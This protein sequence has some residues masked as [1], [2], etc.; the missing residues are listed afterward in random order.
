MPLCT[1]CYNFDLNQLRNAPSGN[2]SNTLS[3]I[4]KSALGGCDLCS[5]VVGVAV[6]H[7]AKVSKHPEAR[8][9]DHIWIQ[10]WLSGNSTSS[11][12]PPRYNKLLVSINTLGRFLPTASEIGGLYTTSP[13]QFEHEICIAASPGSPAYQSGV[14]GGRYLGL[15]KTSAEYIA[16]IGEWMQACISSH[17]E[18]CR[19]ISDGAV[20]D[21]HSVQ[22]PTRCIEVTSTAAYLRET[23]GMVGSYVT[24]SHR[25]NP[26][27]EAY[28]TL[29]SNYQARVSGKELGML[30]KNFEA[31]I[32]IVRRLGIRYLWIDSICIIQGSEDWEVEKWKMGQY[33]G[34]SLF[35]ISAIGSGHQQGSSFLDAPQNHPVTSLVRVPYREHGV[36]KGSIYFYRR[37]KCAD[38]QF[39]EHVDRSELLSRGWVFQEWLLSKRIMYFT[40]NETF[41]EC[42]SQRPQ[43]IC[44]D[45]MKMPT[46]REQLGRKRWP[47]AKPLNNGFKVDFASQ[48]E[49]A[50]ATWYA[51]VRG[52]STT[53]LTNRLDHLAAISG[54]ACEYGDV[55]QRQTSKG[56]E[57]KRMPNYLSGLWLQDIH[58]GLMWLANTVTSP[59]CKC[60][61]PSWSWLSCEAL[62]GWPTRGI[63]AQPML[64]V[65]GAN[66]EPAL[67]GL[68]EPVI[69]TLQLRAK[70][71]IQPVLVAPKI[72]DEGL[73]WRATGV[74]EPKVE[75][76]LRRQE[77]SER[78][79]QE[80]QKLVPVNTAYTVFHPS[81]PDVAGG[82]A[83]FERSPN[84]GEW[85]Q[86]P[87]GTVALAILVA[88]RRT[89]GGSGMFGDCFKI[90]ST[91]YD[92]IF[93]E[94]L[95]NNVFR[96]LGM[97]MIFDWNVLQGF[98]RDECI[99]IIFR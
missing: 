79:W 69:M 2:Q 56:K 91:V 94:S 51:I 33:Y 21:P 75:N 38:H 25:W 28:K 10:L 80:W 62:I 71:K 81:S 44:N 88:S 34:H 92:V 26:G 13:T 70:T 32:S 98:Q 74:Q 53:R 61:A 52:F 16:A 43:S 86:T 29:P 7:V 39:W 99:E 9:D 59:T 90:T 89:G 40:P 72:K 19:A 31:A 78:E 96:R 41:V 95:G 73:M 6:D 93:V 48:P 55:I 77:E 11:R 12:S 76:P 58:H 46:E 20:F 1:A 35:T 60:N 17:H 22:L 66:C 64:Q 50:L 3:A 5:L 82:W 84:V 47:Y 18:C 68:P 37:E 63:H 24:L 83:M 30:S 4:Q 85:T 65:V 14:V 87:S 54:A 45:I 8:D 23:A 42:S 15:D 57:A 36:R 27:A 49:S 97:G 67:P